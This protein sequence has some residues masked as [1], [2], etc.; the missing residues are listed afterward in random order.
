MTR[1]HAY[2]LREMIEKASYSLNDQ[3]A[4][5]A[6]EL[7][8]PYEK[9]VERNIRAEKGFRFRYNGKLYRVEQP[10]VTFDG[11]YAPGV[12]TESLYSEVTLSTSGSIESPIEYSGNMELEEG[13]YY[14]Q[15]NVVYLCTRGTGIPVYNDLQDLVGLYVTLV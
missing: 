1:E 13:K 15:N 14:T 6:V 12:G 5:E 7:F 11:V 8:I 10:T 2:K 4:L 3:D 9:L